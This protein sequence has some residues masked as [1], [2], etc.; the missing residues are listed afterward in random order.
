[1][2]WMQDDQLFVDID[3]NGRL[4]PSRFVEDLLE[5]RASDSIKPV[6]VFRYLGDK[7]PPLP[8]DNAPGLLE[9]DLDNLR[10][11]LQ[12]H[13]HIGAFPS[14]H[15][16]R[17]KR[18]YTRYTVT[19]PVDE[20]GEE[21]SQSTYEA[22]ANDPDLLDARARHAAR[23][24]ALQH[25]RDLL[26]DKKS[27]IWNTVSE[28]QSRAGVDATAA[29]LWAQNKWEK[30]AAE[31]NAILAENAEDDE[32]YD[33]GV[34]LV[35]RTRESVRRTERVEEELFPIFQFNWQKTAAI[36]ARA[37]D[38]DLQKVLSAS[39]KRAVR[40]TED[41]RQRL[42]EL[43]SQVNQKALLEHKLLRFMRLWI[44]H[45]T[46]GD[47]QPYL[48]AVTAAQRQLEGQVQLAAAYARAVGLPFRLEWVL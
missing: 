30:A 19:V 45:C 2:N 11:Y 28:L 9:I 29:G 48:Q 10:R 15:Q 35:T 12:T 46:V 33:T 44:Q 21:I 37:D 47:P 22:L 43:L 34:R 41:N 8:R 24:A 17:E 26:T 23:E 38:A 6:E 39:D 1:M 14:P 5:G 4:C 42:E 20:D 16:A 40:Q 31:A 25:N 18:W 36:T 3:E 32:D 13:N 27:A 7:D